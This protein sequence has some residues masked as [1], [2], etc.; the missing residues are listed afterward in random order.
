MITCELRQSNDR[1][2]VIN[3]VF[4]ELRI[5]LATPQCAYPFNYLPDGTDVREKCFIYQA[6]REAAQEPGQAAC[7]AEQQQEWEGP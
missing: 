3:A 6:A 7:E 1:C 2:S 5:G 4:T